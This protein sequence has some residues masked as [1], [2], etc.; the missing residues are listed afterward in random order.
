MYKSRLQKWGLSKNT[1]LRDVAQ[2]LYEKGRRD[3]LGKTSEFTKE[4]KEIDITRILAYV[5]R[6]KLTERDLIPHVGPSTTPS[7]IICRS[8]SPTLKKQPHLDSKMDEI[9]SNV[10]GQLRTWRESHGPTVNDNLCWK[11]YRK[12][13]PSTWQLKDWIFYGQRCF[14]ESEY[15]RGGMLLRDAFLNIEQSI[16]SLDPITPVRLLYL[17][18]C[19]RSEEV[20]R[21]L[22]DHLCSL[23]LR[24]LQHQHPLSRLLHSLKCL[25]KSSNAEEWCSTLGAFLSKT[26]PGIDEGF[27][28]TGGLTND[29]TPNRNKSAHLLSPMMATVHNEHPRDPDKCYDAAAYQFFS[30]RATYDWQHSGTLEAAQLM[31][32]YAEASLEQDRATKAET[33]KM[34]KLSFGLEKLAYCHKSH[35][36]EG[37]G[38]MDMRYALA[39]QILRHAAEQGIAAD[40]LQS[41][42]VI[43]MLER[44]RRW[45]IEAGDLVSAAEVEHRLQKA[46]ALERMQL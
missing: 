45:H 27:G 9:I 26:L 3:V 21:M 44:L 35:C 8:P 37:S 30:L 2:V 41:P 39:C 29:L 25:I 6:K 46:H 13:T 40:G 16:R 11:G 32:T 24:F 38:Q 12:V 33:G 42:N 5:R 18:R 36:S 1:H 34:G 43:R 10:I 31:V 17:F 4:G 7:R 28:Q 20:A 15:H 22:V 14:E 23:S 19:L